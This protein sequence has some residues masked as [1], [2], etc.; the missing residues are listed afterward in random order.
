MPLGQAALQQNNQSTENILQNKL[1]TFPGEHLL[2]DCR[3][4]V[5]MSAT[6]GRLSPVANWG[7]SLIAWRRICGVC[8][9]KRKNNGKLWN[10]TTKR[11][12]KEYKRTWTFQPLYQVWWKKSAKIE[13]TATYPLHMSITF[14][15]W[16]SAVRLWWQTNHPLCYETIKTYFGRRKKYI[17][18][19]FRQNWRK[20]NLTSNYTHRIINLISSLSNKHNKGL[21]SELLWSIIC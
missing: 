16:C 6:R 11:K 19:R 4:W 17:F 15:Q 9:R 13:K 1:Y 2:P 10:S 12:I 21:G 8:T 14:S 3:S 18:L 20:S 7:S 5:S